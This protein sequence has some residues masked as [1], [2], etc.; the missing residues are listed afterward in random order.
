M[1]SSKRSPD[2]GIFEVHLRRK[3]ALPNQLTWISRNGTPR[4]S[5]ATNGCTVF[6]GL[7][8][9]KHM[10]LSWSFPTFSCAI[11]SRAI[12]FAFMVRIVVGGLGLND[13]E[14]IYSNV[15]EQLMSPKS[16]TSDDIHTSML[17]MIGSC[18]N[19]PGPWNNGLS[20]GG[21]Q[22]CSR[23]VHWIHSVAD[24]GSRNGGIRITSPG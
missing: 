8:F 13:L 7:S 11:E 2:A 10:P 16:A 14:C 22:A 1:Y 9:I 12:L 3:L 5:I 6:C 19:S 18:L 24:K 4:F 21:L 15:T 23:G 17:M 20:G